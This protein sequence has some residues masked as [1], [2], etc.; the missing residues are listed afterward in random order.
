MRQKV[1]AFS[2]LMTHEEE[3]KHGIRVTTRRL[4]AIEC[5]TVHDTG[6]RAG[7]N[8]N[9]TLA[10]IDT[11]YVNTRRASRPCFYIVDMA[12]THSSKP[13]LLPVGCL[14]LPRIRYLGETLFDSV[15]KS[16]RRIRDISLR[17]VRPLALETRKHHN[18]SSNNKP[19]W[20]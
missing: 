1:L 16:G 2:I 9:R 10:H 18:V 5:G 3:V 19:G 7:R 11:S 20:A 12:S 15:D 17:L 14:H 13:R 4:Q 6:Y 8:D